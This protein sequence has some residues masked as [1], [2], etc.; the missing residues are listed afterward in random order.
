MR[1]LMK[2][3]GALFTIGLLAGP[4]VAWAAPGR[5]VGNPS[6][7]RAKV[8]QQRAKVAGQVNAL[9]ATDAQVDSA[10]KAL[11]ANV[12][13][14]QA[15]LAEAQRASAQADQ[16]E[17]AANAAVAAKK[18]EI[19][20][21]K[22][23]IRHFAVE[24]FVHPPGDDALQAMDEADPGKAAEK[25]ALLELQSTNDNDLLDQL[26][27]AEQDLDAERKIAHDAAQRAKSKKADVANKLSGLKAARDA[28]AAFAGQVQD[29]LDQALGEAASLASLDA[30]L[31]RQIEQEELARASA[32]GVGNGGRG[33]GGPVGNVNLG[34]ASCQSGGRITVAA[35]IA[36]NLQRMLNAA[37]A[38]GVNL[39][40]GGYRSSQDQIATRRANGCPDIYNSPPSACHP[41]TARPG[42]S[43]HERGLAVDFTCNGGGVI[44]SRSSPCFQWLNGHASGY[45]FYNLPS[46]P[47]H[48]STNGD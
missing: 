26:T 35:S 47:W 48:W 6:S 41:P 21:L 22:T 34:S 40:G 15:R 39:C 4:A 44:S 37:S 1:A 45:G 20:Q 29:R 42:T 27:A 46:E 16:A 5:A 30:S 3:V 38:D 7:E 32:A 8:R 43:M 33:G 31:A 17:A 24:A 19:D 2:I 10:L 14:Q 23:E 11:N 25:R 9:K 18:A 28:K 13:G 12:S 36:G